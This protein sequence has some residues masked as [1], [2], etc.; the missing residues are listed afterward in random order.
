MPPSVDILVLIII[1]TFTSSKAISSSGLKPSRS[2]VSLIA[3]PLELGEDNQQTF[4]LTAEQ[5][6]HLSEIFTASGLISATYL[7]SCSARFLHIDRLYDDALLLSISLDA[8]HHGKLCGKV[9]QP[10]F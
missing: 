8:W 3:E 5:C 1:T 6:P 10:N 7:D 2:R 4:R 9:K